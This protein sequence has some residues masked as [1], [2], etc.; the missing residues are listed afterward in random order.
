LYGLGNIRDERLYA[1]WHDEGKVTWLR[2]Q[3]AELSEWFNIFV[4]HQ[5]RGQKGGSN[6]YFEDL[7]PS[8]LDLVIWGHEHECKIELQGPNPC[9]TQPGSSIATSLIEGEAVPKHV[10]IL[11]IFRE[12]FKWKPIRLK[13]VRPFV[14]KHIRLDEEKSL[15]NANKDQVEEFL[16]KYVDRL[17]ADVE[18]DFYRALQDLDDDIPIDPRLKQPLVRV[19][20]EY[21]NH[22]ATVNP[23]RF[24]QHFV[25]KIAN[26]SEILKFQRRSNR[27][28][29]TTGRS[30]SLELL[31][32]KPDTSEELSVLGLIQQMLDP[33]SSLHILPVADLNSALEQFVFKSETSA[34]PDFVESYLTKVKK[35][36]LSKNDLVTELNEEEIKAVCRQLLED[37]DFETKE[38]EKNEPEQKPSLEKSVSNNNSASFVR[39]FLDDS[40]EDEKI[41][42]H[43]KTNSRKQSAA[44][45]KTTLS[46]IKK[47][48]PTNTKRTREKALKDV[49]SQEEGAA[50]YNSSTRKNSSSTNTRKSSRIASLVQGSER[51]SKYDF[52]ESGEDSE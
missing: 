46:N 5:N 45:K 20:V 11:E 29:K 33:K 52:D 42:E 48:R 27:N 31:D 2:P 22:Q 49:L 7:F 44:A 16:V 21:G 13:T 39:M 18:A 19:R 15:E 25:G 1:T 28:K 37:K 36:V 3:D 10:A 4:F 24:G 14:M 43:E 17:L 50:T 34:I 12:Q 8:F 6:I 47:S 23:Q 35:V 38:A 9:I 26:S 30:G 41:A 40:E 32:H 51:A